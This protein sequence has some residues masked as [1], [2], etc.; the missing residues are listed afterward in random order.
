MWLRYRGLHITHSPQYFSTVSIRTKSF[1]K[2]AK[3]SRILSQCTPD[4]ELPLISSVSLSKMK[5][6]LSSFNCKY[7][8]GYT[9]LLTRCSNCNKDNQGEIYINKITGFFLCMECQQM[10]DWPDIIPKIKTTDEKHKAKIQHNIKQLEIIQDYS[11]KWRELASM[12]QSV[13]SCTYEE[14][15]N[16]IYLFKLHTSVDKNVLHNLDVVYDR[17]RQILYFPVSNIHKKIVGIMELS[18]NGI[19]KC[20]PFKQCPGI[21][22]Y[23]P[24]RVK[25]KKCE[26]MILVA[27]IRDL[28][29]V[30]S[31]KHNYHV[32]CIPHGV[33]SLPLQILPLLEQYSR[34][35]LWFG[36]D[37]QNLNNARAFSEK[38]RKERC[39]FIRDVEERPS[40]YLVK[41]ENINITEILNAARPATHKCIT[42]FANLRNEIWSTLANIDT[43]EGVKWRRFPALN[44]I[45]RGH[46]PG[47]LTVLTGSTGS[48]KTTFLSEYSLDLAMQGITT[49][50]GSFEIR[51]T[52]LALTMLQQYALAPLTE[53][54]DLFETLAD[55]FERLPLYFL[56]FH[57]Q[58]SINVV[59]DVVEHAT[60]V[61]DIKHLVIDNLQFMMGL[62]SIEE[63]YIDRFYK[64]D[65]VI[66]EFR[67]FATK[68]DCH[69]TLIIHPKKEKDTDD[70]TISSIFG[71]VKASQES[72]NIMIL[73]K[74][75]SESLQLKKYLQVVKN[76]YNGELGIMPLNFNKAIRS[77]GI[78]NLKTKSQ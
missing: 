75:M 20:D 32:I 55:E 47:E 45:L 30:S 40:V 38:L 1:K 3:I 69:V 74:N 78:K 63:R 5:K 26:N 61:H 9:C 73:Q 72:D 2:A 27:S 57:G 13:S 54:L 23:I 33:S 66:A 24:N 6:T 46:R 22:R 70:L 42:T 76:R 16:I 62:S 51:N 34:I 10:G 41:T 49:L 21:L 58:E 18:S 29:A 4:K 7:E 36:N 53:N 60:Y 59:M 8:D 64:Q 12:Y 17:T 14:I 43:A 50:W 48:G 44:E 37:L 11:K 19:E 25:K 52:R 31:E 68:H 77:Y 56:K 71:S 67:T 35:I 65:K 15:K 28:I 39:F